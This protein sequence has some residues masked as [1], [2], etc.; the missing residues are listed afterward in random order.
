MR[1]KIRRSAGLIVALTLVGAVWTCPAWADLFQPLGDLPGDTFM[2]KANGVSADGSVVVGHSDADFGTG[3]QPEAFSWTAL[4]G[5]IGLG[6]IPGGA[7]GSAA[8]GASADGSVVV[9]WSDTDLGSYFETPGCYTSGAWSVLA[10]VRGEAYGVSADGTVIVGRTV[11]TSG[12]A[13]RWTSASGFVVLPSGSA[14]ARGVSANGSIVVGHNDGEAVLWNAANE[15][16]NLGISGQANAADSDASV[17]VGH[18]TAG[19]AFRWTSSG[20]EH[21]GDFAGGLFNSEALAV[22]A[23]GSIVVGYG[24]VAKEG[25]GSRH[26]AFLWDATDGMQHLYDLLVADPD[27]AGWT[28]TD[29]TGISANGRIIVG[30]GINPDGNTEAWRADLSPVPLPGAALLGFLGL[31]VA[32]WRLRRKTLA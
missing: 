23:D 15:R 26:E 17:I 28:L 8:Y 3:G 31:S 2:S 1:R 19:D 20:I 25:G 22:S 4:G 14:G 7:A 5:M 29:A 32:G 9:G 16:V 21:L 24:T 30:Y 11:T 18:A 12:D 27:L 6:D 13:F 10:A